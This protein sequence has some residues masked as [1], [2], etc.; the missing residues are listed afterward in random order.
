MGR[1]CPLCPCN[2]DV[3]LL[4]NFKG[5]I[6][7]DAEVPDRALDLG[8]PKQQLYRSQVASALVNHGGLGSSQ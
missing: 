3:D 8:V 6:D 2:S 7:L 4:G 1:G 5:I